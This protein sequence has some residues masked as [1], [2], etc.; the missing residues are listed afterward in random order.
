MSFNETFQCLKEKECLILFFIEKL[1]FLHRVLRK[2]LQHQR[3]YLMRRKLYFVMYQ[4]KHFLDEVNLSRRKNW[5][6]KK[7]V[8]IIFLYFLILHVMNKCL[9]KMLL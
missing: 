7:P 6:E 4:A 8:F 2:F 5:N 1:K 3:R 9:H